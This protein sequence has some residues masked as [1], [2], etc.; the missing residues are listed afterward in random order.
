M[1][2]TPGFHPGNTGS[3]PVGITT[4]RVC[5][6]LLLIG[7]R[8]RDR[9]PSFMNGEYRHFI[10][11]EVLSSKEAQAKEHLAKYAVERFFADVNPLY[12]ELT[13]FL[14][15][16]SHRVINP[17]DSTTAS[18]AQIS[19]VTNA[20]AEVAKPYPN[21]IWVKTDEFVHA[22][23]YLGIHETSN[24]PAFVNFVSKKIEPVDIDLLNEE[25]KLFVQIY[26]VNQSLGLADQPTVGIST[27]EVV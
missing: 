9:E 11:D 26:S 3:T 20:P 22:N 13:T 19:V 18:H 16:E 15:E 4:N 27:H 12:R 17:G 10:A 23:C 25:M 21:R 7:T 2:R 24:T 14:G 5:E 6:K 1:V 8:M